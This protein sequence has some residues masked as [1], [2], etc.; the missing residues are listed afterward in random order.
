MTFDAFSGKVLWQGEPALGGL[1]APVLTASS[2]VLVADEADLTAYASDG[3]FEAQF[4]VTT[5]AIAPLLLDHVIGPYL[6]S[7]GGDEYRAIIVK[8][9]A[10]LLVYDIELRLCW[11]SLHLCAFPAERCGPET[12]P[13]TPVL[14]PIAA[15]ATV[16]FRTYFPASLVSWPRPNGTHA[17]ARPY[18]VAIAA[19]D[20]SM[21][22]HTLWTLDLSV[23][24]SAWSLSNASG[25]HAVDG[26]LMLHLFADGE[27][28]LLVAVRDDGTSGTVLWSRADGAAAGLGYVA[29]A[30]DPRGG[31]WVVSAAGTHDRTQM[32]NR[33]AAATGEVLQTADVTALGLGR[34]STTARFVVHSCASCDDAA[35]ILVAAFDGGAVAAVALAAGKNGSLSVTWSVQAQPIGQIIVSARQERASGVAGIA[36]I[37]VVFATSRGVVGL[38]LHEVAATRT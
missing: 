23:L 30:A 14:A 5:P 25:V 18:L 38:L 3:G 33:L 16:G 21:R 9:D 36:D 19:G 7:L 35:P 26:V 6:L 34:L 37:A 31:A 13:S 22:V 32:L 12:S 15:P 27:A 4:D 29:L 11:A 2:D 17:H 10:T 28:P 1:G 8:R 20:T 24:G